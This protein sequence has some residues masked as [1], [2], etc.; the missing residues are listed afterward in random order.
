[1]HWTESRYWRT[2]ALLAVIGLFT[3]ALSIHRPHDL[4]VL[5][6]AAAEDILVI[7]QATT[8]RLQMMTTAD[9]GTTLVWWYFKKDNPESMELVDSKVFRIR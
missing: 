4:P 7:P 5:E 6:P 1:M 2:M 8:A 3:L 9:N